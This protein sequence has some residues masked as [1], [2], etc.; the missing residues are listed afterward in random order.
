MYEMEINDIINDFAFDAHLPEITNLM[1]IITFVFQ[2]I[3]IIL[4]SNLLFYAYFRQNKLKINSFSSLMRIYF[5]TY[6]ICGTLSIVT[7]PYIF[8]I[9][10]HGI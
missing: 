6:V 4:M 2:V 10:Q 1:L 5:L 9:Q 7:V 8:L 3:A